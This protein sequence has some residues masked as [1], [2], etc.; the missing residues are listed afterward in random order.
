MTLARGGT[1][2]ILSK[3]LSN[4]Q[5]CEGPGIWHNILL[6]YVKKVNIW[7]PTIT[8][9]SICYM[10][11][12]LN[13]LNLLSWWKLLTT[14]SATHH[15]MASASEPVK[16]WWCLACS[17]LNT[18]NFTNKH[19]LY[20][21]VK[22]RHKRIQKAWEEGKYPSLLDCDLCQP[23]RTKRFKCVAHIMTHIQLRHRTAEGRRYRGRL[24]HMRK[25][26]EGEWLVNFIHLYCRIE[27]FLISFFIQG[28]GCCHRQYVSEWRAFCAFLP[29]DTLFNVAALPLSMIAMTS[30]VSIF[31]WKLY[32][33][34]K[35]RAHVFS[36][37][38]MVCMR[39]HSHFPFKVVN[40]SAGQLRA[41]SVLGSWSKPA[42]R[43]S[44]NAL[45]APLHAWHPSTVGPHHTLLYNIYPICYTSSLYWYT[46]YVACWL[47]S[48]GWAVG[49]RACAVPYPAA[50]LYAWL[51]SARASGGRLGLC[52]GLGLFFIG[53]NGK[54]AQL[55][56]KMCGTVIN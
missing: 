51:I 9:P 54:S 56:D 4:M 2:L 50:I 27:F 33:I 1:P 39:S 11:L 45:P 34:L 22:D 35:Y 28:A 12:L 18:P 53:L 47:C 25:Q 20:E 5:P 48:A 3:L 37:S 23:P 14:K 55:F 21:H 10:I 42:S 43:A 8:P 26:E 29:L 40:I 46:V 16:K 36:P 44:P 17:H 7:F 52:C 24:Q 13:P 41:Q 15:M 38:R 30:W 32:M 19:D 6:Q 49:A 31:I